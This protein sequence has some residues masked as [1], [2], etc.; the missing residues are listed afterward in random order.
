MISNGFSYS[1]PDIHAYW[2]AK[3]EQMAA[4]DDCEPVIVK[5][6]TR[7]SDV[8][9]PC[10]RKPG[11]TEFRVDAQKGKNGTYPLRLHCDL[12]ESKTPGA[13]AGTKL[14]ADIV[15]RSIAYAIQQQKQ[16]KDIEWV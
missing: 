8:S 7:A 16:W 5:A 3:A 13:I 9:R 15:I 2:R 4:T 11:H 10:R 14:G 12:C 6:D 1:Q